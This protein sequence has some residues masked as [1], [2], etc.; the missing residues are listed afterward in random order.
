MERILKT[1]DYITTN[2]PLATIF[3]G[4]LYYEQPNEIIQ[5]DSTSTTIISQRRTSHLGHGFRGNQPARG[6]NKT[7]ARQ[8]GYCL[9]KAIGTQAENY[10]LFSY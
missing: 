7:A 1:V 9:R 3:I 10:G 5:S 4:D 8:R 6:K 2:Y